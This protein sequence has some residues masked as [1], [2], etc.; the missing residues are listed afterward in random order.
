MEPHW[1]LARHSAEYETAASL[2]KLM[3]QIGADARNLAGFSRVQAA[4][5]YTKCFVGKTVVV[6]EAR[7]ELAASSLPRMRTS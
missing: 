1:R 3:G 5:S 2:S 6:P 4:T 7:F